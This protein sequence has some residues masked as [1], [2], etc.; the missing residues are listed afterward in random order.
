VSSPPSPLPPEEEISFTALVL[1]TLVHVVLVGAL[2][3]GVQWKSQAPSA[4]DVEIWRSV[5]PPPAARPQPAP[6]PPPPKPEPA[7]EPLPEPTPLPEPPPP[8]PPPPA[9]RP[10]PVPEPPPPALPDP[11]IAI[12]EALKKEQ[13]RLEKEQLE[14][15]RLEKERLERERLEKERL[16]KERLEKERLEKERLEKER[17]EK[18]RLEKERLEKERLEKERLEKER[19][20]K[21]RL[22]RERQERQRKEDLQKQAEREAQR[23]RELRNMIG[24]AEAEIRQMRADQATA[25]RARGERA[26][27]DN[28]RN[29]IRGNIVLPLNIQGN[30]EAEFRVTQLP[31]GDIINVRISKSSGNSALDDAIERAIRKSSPLPLPDDPGLFQRE[32]NLKYKPFDE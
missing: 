18:E 23:Q 15:E 8:P 11:D 22:E 10:E 9:P 27:T 5:A 26:W 1:A 24:G 2:F 17:L 6:V 30:P 12:K 3:L 31:S 32:F 13:E 29:K 7:P 19:L 28:V 14:R 20:E 21:A 16:E 4:V 25:A